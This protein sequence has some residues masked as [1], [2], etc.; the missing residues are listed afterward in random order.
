MTLTINQWNEFIKLL[1]VYEKNAVE[2]VEIYNRNYQLRQGPYSVKT[3]LDLMKHVRE[4]ECT[5]DRR[6]SEWLS[7]CFSWSCCENA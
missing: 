5:C 7:I 4:F 6:I 2:T 1:Y 3:V